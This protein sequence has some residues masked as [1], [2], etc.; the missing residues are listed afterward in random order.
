MQD[1]SLD[2]VYGDVRM[3][4][5]EAGLVPFPRDFPEGL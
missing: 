2:A 1:K 5:D 3:F 4:F